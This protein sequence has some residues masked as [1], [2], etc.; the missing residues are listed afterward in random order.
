MGGNSN[1]YAFLQTVVL[2]LTLIALVVY[3]HFTRKTQQAMVKQTTVNVLPCFIAY[4]GRTSMKNELD[5]T[6]KCLELENIGNGI[7]LNVTVDTLDIELGAA[8]EFI[9]S[10]HMVF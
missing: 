2:T 9:P 4:V 8:I 6:V 3:T 7:A 5:K 10:P 1:K